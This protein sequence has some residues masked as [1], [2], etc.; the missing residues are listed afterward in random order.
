MSIPV[1]YPERTWNVPGTYPERIQD[2]PFLTDFLFENGMLRYGRKVEFFYCISVALEIWRE[3]PL[4]NGVDGFD[5]GQAGDLV[6][7]SFHQDWPTALQVAAQQV[8]KM[9]NDLRPRSNRAALE[10]QKSRSASGQLAMGAY[11]QTMTLSLTSWSMSVCL[12]RAK[13]ALY[14]SSTYSLQF[15]PAFM[16]LRNTLASC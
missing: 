16:A 4:G 9:A 1:P 15:I 8:A 10:F 12:S 14:S 5:S 13:E 7:E 6:L 2:V 3:D 11:T